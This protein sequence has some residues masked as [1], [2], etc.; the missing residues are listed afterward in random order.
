MTVFRT[1][2]H[3]WFIYTEISSTNS[4][5]LQKLFCWQDLKNLMFRL[6]NNPWRR[7]D[8]LSGEI[9]AIYAAQATSSASRSHGGGGGGGGGKN[10]TASALDLGDL[11]TRRAHHSGVVSGHELLS[12]SFL[13]GQACE[14]RRSIKR[15]HRTRYYS[16]QDCSLSPGV[17]TH[18]GHLN[19]LPCLQHNTSA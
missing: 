5:G 3:L 18:T 19:L 12:Y 16:D 6:K 10:S 9:D 7:S 1:A 13:R 2:F 8:R 17:M 14:P 15:K 11:F 4:N